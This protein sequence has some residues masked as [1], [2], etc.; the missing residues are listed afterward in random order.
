MAKEQLG[1]GIAR[2][3]K[4]E[5][6]FRQSHLVNDSTAIIQPLISSVDSFD[7]Q[8]LD[9]EDDSFLPQMRNL[10]GPE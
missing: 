7:P 5:L 9:F 2:D 1:M 8:H 4:G 3:D 10:H 6:I